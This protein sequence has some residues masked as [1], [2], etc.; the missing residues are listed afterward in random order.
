MASAIVYFSCSIFWPSVL[1]LQILLESQNF[2]D[3]RRQI[4]AHLVHNRLHVKPQMLWLNDDNEKC[5]CQKESLLVKSM[6]EAKCSSEHYLESMMQA[7][8][9]SRM[10]WL[11]H[12]YQP[13]TRTSATKIGKGK[14]LSQ[15]FPPPG[16]SLP[17]RW[18]VPGGKHWMTLEI[19]ISDTG[20]ISPS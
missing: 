3:I 6:W 12:F 2:P 14:F 8:R 4:N 18:L 17:W 15:G 9:A 5:C 10:S 13:G 20:N 11:F 1:Q 19:L 7:S 16:N